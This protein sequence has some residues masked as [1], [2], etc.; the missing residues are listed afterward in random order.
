MIK[1]VSGFSILIGLGVAFG[2]GWSVAQ[3]GTRH[4]ERILNLGVAVLVAALIVSRAFYVILNWGYY[5][6]HLL[7]ALWVW[8]GGLSG[9]GALLGGCLGILL[10]AWYAHLSPAWLAD[11]LMPLL[12]SLMVAGW[13]G[14]WLAGCAYGPILRTW[15][16]LPSRDEWG[17]SDWRFPVQFIGA[18]LSVLGLSLLERQRYLLRRPGMTASLA[19]CASALLL[20]GLSFL[21]SDPMPVWFGLRLDA[22]GA[23]AALAVSLVFG[24]FCFLF[25]R[26]EQ[27]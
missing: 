25:P 6:D 7:E 17:I 21:R 5:R 2:L 9:S 11:Q 15:W 16:A 13:L 20:F 1:L 19:L 12:T 24:L 22:W 23:L 14:C 3:A 10:A 18:V 26:L 8:Q 27:L 4:A